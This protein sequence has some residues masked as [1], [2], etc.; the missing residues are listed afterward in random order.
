[1]LR[2]ILEVKCMSLFIFILKRNLGLE[3]PLIVH[4]TSNTQSSL[5]ISCR[6]K[7]L[8]EKQRA[9]YL[10]DWP[11][12][13]DRPSL[14]TARILP[15]AEPVCGGAGGGCSEDTPLTL[16]QT[17]FLGTTSCCRLPRALISPDV[18]PMLF[19]H[20]HSGYGGLTLS[21]PE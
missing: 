12:L 8:L 2:Q 3:E 19:V 15:V 7:G 14:K 17:A 11:K 9:G 20:R 10:P 1:M 21:R 18:C 4:L 6:G 5:G 13:E 16:A